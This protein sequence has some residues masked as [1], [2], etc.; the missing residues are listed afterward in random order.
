M[1]APKTMEAIE[2]AVAELT[3]MRRSFTGQD[4]H[5][6]IHNRKIRRPGNPDFSSCQE[7]PQ[8]IS[9]EV[10][11]LFNRRHSLFRDYGSANV[12]HPNG[13]ILYFPLPY[14]AKR[15]INNIISKL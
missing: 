3:R 5:Q 4:V 9:L 12:Y 15:R 7:R 11:L 6:R 10:R 8:E 13:P 1:C 14:H 2:T